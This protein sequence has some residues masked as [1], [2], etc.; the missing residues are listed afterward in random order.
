[1]SRYWS[2][3]PKMRTTRAQ[4]YP[5]IFGFTSPSLAKLQHNGCRV[6][7]AVFPPRPSGPPSV[8]PLLRSRHGQDYRVWLVRQRGGGGRSRSRVRRQEDTRLFPRPEA[9]AVRR[10]RKSGGRVRAR[11]SADEHPPPPAH[12]PVPGRVFP[13]RLADAGAS[14]GEA[15]DQ[16]PRH[17]GSRASAADEGLHPRLSE[18]L[19]PARRCPRD[20]VPAQPHAAHHPPRPFR[21]KRSPERGDGGQDS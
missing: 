14:H 16:S 10:H 20:L 18:T 5:E 8:P 3:T 12:R 21:Q 11:V 9:D 2:A 7:G 1:M 6:L 19:H 17:S 4:R 15:G 13:A